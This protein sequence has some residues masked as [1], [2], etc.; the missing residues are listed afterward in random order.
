MASYK[1][2]HPSLFCNSHP[3][4]RQANFLCQ[5][6]LLY[7]CDN[8]CPGIILFLRTKF[9]IPV[10]SIRIPVTMALPDPCH[11][12]FAIML[13]RIRAYIK[14]RI[15]PSKMSTMK[16]KILVYDDNC[17][18][19][20]WYTG[21]FIKYG[22][23]EHGGRKAFSKLD[24]ATLTKID[25]D[26]SRNEIP[27]LDTKTMK[28]EYGIDALI[29]ILDQ[30]I[31]LVRRLGNLAPIKWSLR[32]LYKLVSFNRKVIVARKCGPGNI[33]CSPDTN[34]T[35][36]FFFMAISLLFNTAMIIPLHNGLFSKLS[37]YRINIFEMQAA[38]FVFV[39]SNC[40]LAFTFKKQKGYEYLG[41]VNM[42]ALSA[43]LLLIPLLLLNLL[44]TIEWINTI[45][46][47]IAGLFIFKEYFRRM[48]YAGV[49]STYKWVVGVN[50]ICLTA[51]LLF[52]FH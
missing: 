14:K 4:T 9:F 43:I 25:F 47:L 36:R 35:Y 2:D 48:K 51:F 24:A 40:A 18:L 45:Y 10:Y 37:Y 29:T 46:L 11:I 16:N 19:C 6:L 30:K 52:L 8:N 42:L 41:Q 23:L 38:H 12:L 21:L 13:E 39:A 15:D 20:S 17:P 33:D 26:R 28:V 31:P 27:L 49:L 50:I 3:P 34:F 32:K 1:H 22:F 5:T 7:T 44:T